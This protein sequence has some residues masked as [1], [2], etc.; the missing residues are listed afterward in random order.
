MGNYIKLFEEFIDIIN[1]NT[2]KKSTFKMNIDYNIAQNHLKALIYFHL[3]KLDSLR[4][5]HS[6]MESNSGLKS[7]IK[8]ISLGSLSHYNNNINYEILIPIMNEL[9]NT[10]LK[11]ITID[12]KLKKFGA[13]KLIDSSTISMAITYFKWAK[14]RSTKAGIKLH[15]KFDLAKGVPEQIIVSNA[16]IHD[17]TKLDELMTEKNAIYIYDKAYID[18]KKFDKLDSNEKQF[19]TRLKDNA[20]ASEVQSLDVT[21]SETQ[22]LDKETQIIYDKIVYLGN[23]CNKTKQKYRIVKV[24]TSEYKELIFLTNNFTLSSE[25]IAWLYKKRWEIELFFKWIKQNLKIKRFIGHSLNAVMMQIIT[26]IITFIMLKLVK[27][28]SNSAYGLL[29]IR[30]LIK[31]S[32]T[33]LVNKDIFSWALWLGG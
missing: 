8:G 17:K 22:L 26:A 3:A 7:L 27:D 23:D 2:L 28:H 11:S 21:Y 6:F 19:I 24:I 15:T 30:R 18:Y 14:F 32:I 4:D 31:Y 9:I 1:W 16:K 20:I 12:E 25:E 33:E 5:I 29:K 13:I 10:A